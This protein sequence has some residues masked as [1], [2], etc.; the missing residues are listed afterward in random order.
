[1]RKVYC[2]RFDKTRND[3][4]YWCVIHTAIGENR[5]EKKVDD[6]DDNVLNLTVGIT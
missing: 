3:L 6:D 1:M 4:R 5:L 2:R